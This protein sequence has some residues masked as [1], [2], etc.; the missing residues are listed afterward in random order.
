[1]I[2][3]K[4]KNL[5]NR[6]PELVSAALLVY[7]AI[8]MIR[9]F[10]ITVPFPYPVEYGEGV[11]ANWSLRLSQ[12][13]LLYPAISPGDIPWLHNPYGPLWFHVVAPFVGFGKSVFLAPRLLS[14]IG[15]LFCLFFLYRL[16]RRDLAPAAA[17][18]ACALFAASPLV[19]RFTAMARVDIPALAASLAAVW[20]ME[21]AIHNTGRTRKSA[22]GGLLQTISSESESNKHP[23]DSWFWFLA[24]LLAAVAILIKP[25]FIAALLAGVV[26]GFRKGRRTF[27]I[28]A[29]GVIIPLLIAGIWLIASGNTAIIYHYG[30]MN[31]IGSSLRTLLRLALTV[32]GRHPF[33]FAILL[34]GLWT[35]NRHSPRWWFALFTVI[36]LV[37]SAKVGA[38]VHYYLAPIAAAVLLAGPTARR[39]AG[40]KRIQ[41]ISWCLAAQLA[42]YLPIA[43]QPVFT[44]TYGQEVPAGQ[45]ILTPVEADREIGRLLVEEIGAAKGPVLTDD[46]GYVL[47]AKKQIQLQ[48]FQYGWLVRRGRLDPSPLLQKIREGYFSLIII[49]VPRPD[50][51]GASDFPKEVIE[52]VEKSCKL[53]REIGPYRI[54]ARGAEAN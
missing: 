7:L 4:E 8:C 24:G 46:I 11:I 49:R 34:F 26:I 5:I 9:H 19:W 40:H 37:T 41:T 39:F 14:V 16:S 22:S 3:R 17:L 27:A 30:E 51:T 54:Y 21:M 38:D 28:F 45:T 47:S 50:G 48:P 12:G 13:L 44:A 25:L 35:G 1:M 10:L 6:L 53:A 42:L 52:T 20:L 33:I 15:F 2:Y 43:A 31:G 32:C 29:I 18:G 36:S 23:L